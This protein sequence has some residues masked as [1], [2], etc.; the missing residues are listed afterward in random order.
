MGVEITEDKGVRG[1]QDKGARPCV[2]LSASDGRGLDIEE[3]EK[4][5][6]WKLILTQR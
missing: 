1:V 4:E 5:R 2:E 3:V 6:F